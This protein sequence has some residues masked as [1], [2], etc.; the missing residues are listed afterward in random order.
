MD[1]GFNIP[2]T[3][4]AYFLASSTVKRQ[5]IQRLGRVL[6]L[7]P[8]TQ[9]EKARVHDFVVIPQLDSG[10]VDRDLKSLLRNEFGRMSFFSK[11]SSNGLESEGSIELMDEFLSLLEKNK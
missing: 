1:E 5:W 4:T 7:S 8:S 9:K 10:M 11:L 2:Q 6:R 3:E